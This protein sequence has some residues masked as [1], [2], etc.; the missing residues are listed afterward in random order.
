MFSSSIIKNVAIIICF[1]IQTIIFTILNIIIFD[2]F[3]YFYNYGFSEKILF[4]MIFLSFIQFI[5]I[6][7]YYIYIHSTFMNIYNYMEHDEIIGSF[8]P[9]LLAIYIISISFL[10]YNILA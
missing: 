7:I 1:I 2:G 4:T 6:T 5:N 9:V 10:F 3:P 8:C